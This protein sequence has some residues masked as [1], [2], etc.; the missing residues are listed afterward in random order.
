MIPTTYAPVVCYPAET[1][2]TGP[3]RTERRIINYPH[4]GL[5]TH[6]ATYA[7]GPL[8][9]EEATC[10]PLTARYSTMENRTA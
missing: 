1:N 2:T 4:T 10:G 9:S 5:P 3:G 8:D 6:G 7:R